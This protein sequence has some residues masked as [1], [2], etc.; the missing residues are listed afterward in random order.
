[1]G[2]AQIGEN[3][4]VN[5]R[6]KGLHRLQWPG[7]IPLAETKMYAGLTIRTA[8]PFDQKRV[9][10]GMSNNQAYLFDGNKMQLYLPQAKEYLKGNV[11]QDGV[12]LGKDMLVMATLSG[13]AVAIDKKNNA[14]R[15]IL[16]YQTGLPDDEVFAM[17]TDNQG[18]L[19]LC[20]AKGI[21]RADQGL[22]LRTFSGYAGLEGNIEGLS[23]VN[24]SLFVATSDGLFYL[25]KVDRYEE[26][27]GLIRK[28]QRYLR[29][30]EVVTKTLKITE[31]RLG[32][33]I[34]RYQISK[35]GYK[36][37]DRRVEQMEETETKRVPVST[38]STETITSLF[39]TTEARRAYAIQSIPFI[40][41]K[42][43]GLDAKCRQLL[44]HQRQLLAATNL[45]LYR[46]IQTK[47]EVYAEPI[48]R[49]AYVN[50]ILPSTQDPSVLYVATSQGITQ[51][52]YEKGQWRILADLNEALNTP[53]TS[54]LEFKN[55]LWL[56]AESRVFKVKLDSKLAMGKPQ[57]HI[58]QNS[59]SEEVIVRLVKGQPAFI[60]TSGLHSYSAQ[61]DQFFKNPRLERY[62]SQKSKVIYKQPGFTWIKNRA[63]LNLSQPEA[64]DTLRTLF[65]DFF[66][67]VREIYVVC[68]KTPLAGG[69]QYSLSYQCRCPNERIGRF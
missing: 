36:A 62:F 26:I 37:E 42:V 57:K 38:F 60:L 64:S 35:D 59:Y 6:G 68:P 21:S 50:F 43:S 11:I 25:Y 17:C 34:R 14:T 41:K 49:D 23:F 51:L 15:Y 29:T 1:M 20:H 53:I 56:G 44:Y 22:P 2:L 19:W 5:L 3:I 66:E 67:N 27:E 46:I 9:L 13:G 58:F 8:V 33:R 24:D 63:W 47:A 4:Y 61:K 45:G 10:L 39:S 31:P 12:L 48:L 28:E 40:Y 54:I 52:K 32:T 7:Y 18:G 55:D 65:L 16:N 30:V 69:W